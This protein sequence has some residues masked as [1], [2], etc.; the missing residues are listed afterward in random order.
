MLNARSSQAFTSLTMLQ[1][2]MATLGIGTCS[3]IPIVKN[4]KIV[5]HVMVKSNST[6][7]TIQFW[8]KNDLF[9]F[10]AYA[11]VPA[12]AKMGYNKTLKQFERRQPVMREGKEVGFWSYGE[13][14]KKTGWAK[15]N[16]FISEN[17]I[18]SVGDRICSP[19][20]AD[21][22]LMMVGL[23]NMLGQKMCRIFMQNGALS[24]CDKQAGFDAAANLALEYRLAHKAR[25]PIVLRHQIER[26]GGNQR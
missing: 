2:M 18:F 21:I 15:I 11:Q 26:F 8:R 3:S 7:Y 10:D 25:Q 19:Y 5:A 6:Q 16:G 20:I 9:S 23:N 24:K 13:P 17:T 1:Y 12:E 22:N 14:D 4:K